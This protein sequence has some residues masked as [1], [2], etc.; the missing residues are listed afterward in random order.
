MRVGRLW[1]TDTLFVVLFTCLLENLTTGDD[2]RASPHTSNS[3]LCLNSF[4][5]P[6][7]R[8]DAT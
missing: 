5:W 3:D 8:L 2:S 7:G 6:D 1:L 4:I